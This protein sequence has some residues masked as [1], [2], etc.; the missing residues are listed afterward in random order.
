M[1]KRSMSQA[2]LPFLLPAYNEEDFI[3]GALSG[4]D[5][6]AKKTSYDMRLLR[7]TMVLKIKLCPRQEPALLPRSGT[8]AGL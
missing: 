3:E 8:V 6:V 5:E 2:E 7:W 4:V 1:V